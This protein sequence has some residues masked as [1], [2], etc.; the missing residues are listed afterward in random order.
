MAGLYTV[1]LSIAGA[2]Q[3][4]STSPVCTFNEFVALNGM[5]TDVNARIV[6]YSYTTTGAA[7]DLRVVL[8]PPTFATG[9]AADII[10]ENR[11]AANSEEVSEVTQ[12]CGPDGLVV[13]R[14]YGIEATAQPFTI[15]SAVSAATTYQLFV[16]TAAKAAAGTFYIWYRIDGLDGN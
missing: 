14:R 2:T 8:T 5:P 10:L 12:I 11:L 1:K 13:P 3:F 9:G 6:G 4:V 16:S 7:H 15:A